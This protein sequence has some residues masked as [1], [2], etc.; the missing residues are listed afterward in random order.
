MRCPFVELAVWLWWLVAV[1]LLTC[2]HLPAG[3]GSPWHS[4]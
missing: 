2:L 4:A 3:W 1:V